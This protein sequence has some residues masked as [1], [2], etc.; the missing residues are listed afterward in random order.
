MSGSRLLVQRAA[1]LFAEAGGKKELSDPDLRQL[2][3][4]SCRLLGAAHPSMQSM[5]AFCRALKGILKKPSGGESF[6]SAV[7]EFLAQ[8]SALRS[9]EVVAKISEHAA[10][11]L[12][13]VRRIVSHSYSST[14]A[15][16]LAEVAKQR[17]GLELIQSVS[18][19]AREGLVSAESAAE[20]GIKVILVADAGLPEA[21]RGSDAVVV[22]ADSVGLE[23][24][25]NKLGT[26]GL[27]ITARY[28]SVPLFA[29]FDSTKLRPPGS[30]IVIEEKN[31]EELAMP[32]NK[33]ITVRNVYF[34]LTPLELFTAFINEDGAFPP[35]RLKKKLSSET[36]SCN[37]KS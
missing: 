23:G 37:K 20:S 11:V 12:G 2:L 30:K 18:E 15:R 24:V 36:F 22:G 3:L 34:D 6:R 27:A 13:C 7:R 1:D 5:S 26:L 9:D 10:T 32:G 25:V 19:P 28:F 8:W 29:L 14:V 4:H 21:L 33:K 35:D 17:A 31:P 16:V